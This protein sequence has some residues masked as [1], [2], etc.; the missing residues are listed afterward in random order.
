MLSS[1]SFTNLSSPWYSTLLF[2]RPDFF[3]AYEKECPSILLQTT[4]PA[5]ILCERYA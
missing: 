4:L 5:I 1:C 2:L 3:K